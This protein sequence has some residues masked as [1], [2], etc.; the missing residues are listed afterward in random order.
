MMP[1]SRA[2]KVAIWPVTSQVWPLL[3]PPRHTPLRVKSFG[4]SW[5]QVAPPP[6]QLA[7][8]VHPFEHWPALQTP[9]GGVVLLALIEHAC[10]APLHLPPQTGQGCSPTM[11]RK[12]LV[13]R[14]AVIW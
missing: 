8:K 14:L 5:T 13:R 11:P 9:F 6:P 10:G 12:T 7:S 4:A 2:G 3:A 1:P